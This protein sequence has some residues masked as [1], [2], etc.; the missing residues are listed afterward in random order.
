MSERP[1]DFILLAPVYGVDALVGRVEHVIVDP[2]RGKTTHLVVR[3]QQQPHT[4]RLVPEKYI[5]TAGPEGVTLS[6]PKKNVAELR[7]YIQTEYY[8]PD[9]FL[10]LAKKEH[11]K[12]PLAPSGW[13]VEHP[14][15]PEGAIALVGHDPVVCEPVC[16]PDQGHLPGLHHWR[17]RTDQGRDPGE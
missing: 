4:L 12:L 10:A 15:T 5:A 14:A 17:Q 13:S 3:E 2:V 9:Y 16:V 7:E 11:C 6:L 8:S 1:F